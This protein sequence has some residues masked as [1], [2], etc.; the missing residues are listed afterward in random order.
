MYKHLSDAWI[1]VIEIRIN[2]RNN[3]TAVMEIKVDQV[4]IYIP[5]RS[6]RPSTFNEILSPENDEALDSCHSTVWNVQSNF[7]LT[8]VYILNTKFYIRRSYFLCQKKFL[9][10]QTWRKNN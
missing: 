5:P 7:Q 6:T 4:Q 2:Q 1:S 9:F 10:K 8:R 3:V